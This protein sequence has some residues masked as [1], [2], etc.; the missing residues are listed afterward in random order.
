MQTL[1]AHQMAHEAQEDLAMNE[2]T[3]DLRIVPLPQGQEM[4]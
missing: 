2:S 1:Q 3:T 4:S